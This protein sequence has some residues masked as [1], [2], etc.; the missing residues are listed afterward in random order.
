LSGRAGEVAA[1]RG[2]EKI[3]VS[4]S[5]TGDLAIAVAQAVGGVAVK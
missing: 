1:R 2:V 4:V 3:L 5:H